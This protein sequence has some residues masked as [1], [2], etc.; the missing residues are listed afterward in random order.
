MNLIVQCDGGLCNRLNN[1][2]NGIYLSKLLGRK[3]YIWWD[4]NHACNCA[5]NKLFSNELNLNYKEVW[6]DDFVYYSDFKDEE[7]LHQLN[8][9]GEKKHRRTPHYDDYERTYNRD[10]DGIHVKWQ[11]L[12]DELKAIQSPTL[13]FS[14]SVIFAE[15]IPESE[16]LRILA[17]LTPIPQLQEK[18]S[19]QLKINRI[20][21]SVVGIHIRR[22]D[23]GLLH[24]HHIVDFINK[25]L[26]LNKEQRFLI[27]SDSQATENEFYKLYPDNII[28]LNGYIRTII[29]NSRF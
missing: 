20:D 14:S 12:T 28:I 27:C 7:Q 15:I 10:N 19:E 22:T 9:Y 17:L 11:Q 18:I 23:Y 2:I 24:D 8:S 6:S 29:N 16:V 21:K 1:V 25:K 13:I 26:Q 3:L 4:L 5:F